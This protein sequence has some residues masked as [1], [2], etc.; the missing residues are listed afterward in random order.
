[1]VYGLDGVNDPYKV[2][3]AKE[4]LYGFWYVKYFVLSFL[5]KPAATLPTEPRDFHLMD[6]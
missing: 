1:M 6:A 4:A 2:T 3:S 5:A